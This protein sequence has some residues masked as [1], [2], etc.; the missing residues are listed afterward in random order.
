MSDVVLQS[1]KSARERSGFT[2]KEVEDHLGM[3]S[4]MMRDYESGRLKL[5]LV[6]AMDLARLYKVSLDE[7]ASGRSIA[8]QE[9][10]S[11]FLSRFS[12][13]FLSSGFE[14]MY[15]DP[16]IR[17]FLEGLDEKKSRLSF[18]DLVTEEM[19]KKETDSLIIELSQLMFT[20][21]SLDKKLSDIEVECIKYIL[22]VFGLSK[23]YKIIVDQSGHFFDNSE[24]PKVMKKLEVRH[25]AVWLLFY[26]L[27]ANKKSGYKEVAFVEKCAEK[28]K[29]NKSNFLFIKRHFVREDV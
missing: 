3:R 23:K 8:R 9:T 17:G 14:S 13:L 22:G 7:L 4:L 21:A 1:L 19:S 27:Q 24:I 5:P 10:H 16:I 25:F 2:Q 18:Y 29:I 20:V 11:Q 6:V 26:F 15:H 28:L 12:S